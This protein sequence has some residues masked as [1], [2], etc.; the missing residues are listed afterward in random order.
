[1]L[2]GHLHITQAALPNKKETLIKNAALLWHIILI[3][4]NNKDHYTIPEQ[5]HITSSVQ[6]LDNLSQPP[7]PEHTPR[8]ASASEFTVSDENKAS[9]KG[10]LKI[11]PESKQSPRNFCDGQG[12]KQAN[13]QKRTAEGFRANFTLGK[14]SQHKALYAFHLALLWVA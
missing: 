13:L 11:T 8:C 5:C 1:M 6:P 3:Y 10:H 2:N 9:R 4:Y 12:N 7:F 14:K